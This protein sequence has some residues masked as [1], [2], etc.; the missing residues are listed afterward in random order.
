MA[1]AHFAL[2]PFFYFCANSIVYSEEM[3][4]TTFLLN[5]IVVSAKSDKANG[6]YVGEGKM[7]FD[8]E[9]VLSGARMLGEADILNSVKRTGSVSVSSDY[10]SGISVNG[11]D[12]YQTTIQINS[13]PIIFPY[14]FGGFFS[15]F[16]T[17]HF[18][19][20]LFEQDIHDASFPNYLGAKINFNSKTSIP[21]RI[22]GCFNLGL[23]SSTLSLLIPCGNK[24]MLNASA[25]LSYLNT[26]YTKL[27]SG[28][29]YQMAYDFGDYNFSAVYVPDSENTLL[30]EGYYGEDHLAYA[31]D[32]YNMSIYMPW[33]NAMASAHWNRLKD[34]YSLRN[35][36]F[37]TSLKNRLDVTQSTLYLKMPSAISQCGIAS[38]CN[39]YN[40]QTRFG[41]E[42]NY[43]NILPQY[44]SSAEIQSTKRF[45]QKM[46]EVRAYLGKTFLISDVWSLES[47]LSSS[48]WKNL[49]SRFRFSFNPR[50]TL[51]AHL[52]NSAISVHAGSYSQYLHQV[53]FSEIGL[54]SNFY[55]G[56]DDS[57]P[58]QRSLSF[59]AVWDLTINRTFTLS[60]N[61][62]YK[63]LDGQTEYQ[64]QV[65]ELYDLDYSLENHLIIGSGSNYGVNF[66]LL[67]TAG[68]LT[69]SVSYSYG[70]TIRKSKQYQYTYRSANDLGHKINLVADYKCGKPWLFS[71]S[72][73]MQSG[74][75]YT[76]SQV[77]YIIGKNLLNEYG[78]R[79]SARF[80][81]YHRLDLS[82][83]YTF[84]SK[85]ATSL[86][87][88]Q[89][90]ISIIN[91]Y[92]HRNTELQF[93]DVNP[94]TNS[95][96]IKRVSS[97]Y[98]FLP[99]LSYSIIF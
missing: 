45:K 7:R 82:A 79:N 24:F 5:D 26:F 12:A 37:F 51:R 56:S 17:P 50:I 72:F 43:F 41:Y 49:A 36:I 92:G 86:F 71:L 32:N 58:A 18:S 78:R 84:N 95:I 94:E 64:G 60:V 66:Q 91:A 75:P 87:S 80:P 11:N 40:S 47:G 93:F 19:G 8:S 2:L 16:S 70:A 73:A 65:L 98:R 59:S 27:F 35:R 48:L 20:S 68:E 10:T 53:G 85:I 57:T 25:R 55:I 3:A 38:D 29:S 67:K 69:G 46:F 13:V 83:T 15:V 39:M 42:I 63:I 96:Y 44:I 74:R 23:I 89:I 28:K 76:P 6:A 34:S 81:L 4:D 88:N 62:Y 1:M 61:P 9:S 54:A 22:K 90:N 52:H 33:T 31:D 97:L 30:F 99:S 14:R 21:K 77:M